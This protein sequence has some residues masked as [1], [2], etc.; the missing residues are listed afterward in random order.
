[1]AKH[2]GVQTNLSNSLGLDGISRSFLSQTSTSLL[3]YLQENADAHDEVSLR[4]LRQEVQQESKKINSPTL[5][6]HT[7]SVQECHGGA[8]MLAR[9]T[10]DQI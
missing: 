9:E 4:A 3:R 6:W 2:F 1:M 10:S 5:L 7:G 8:L